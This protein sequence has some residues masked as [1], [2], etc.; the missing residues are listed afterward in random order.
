[1][2][3][4]KESLEISYFISGSSQKK[5]LGRCLQALCVCL[6]VMCDTWA[7]MKDNSKLLNKIPGYDSL[8]ILKH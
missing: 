4:A 6:S 7:E 1:M 3:Q 5:K 2:R 8:D